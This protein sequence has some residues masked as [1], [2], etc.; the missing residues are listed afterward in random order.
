MFGLIDHVDDKPECFELILLALAVALAQ[1]A[2]LG[3]E[4]H[5]REG[6][7]ALVA[8]ELAENAPLFRLVVVR[9]V[10]PAT[11]GDPAAGCWASSSALGSPTSAG[12]GSG[13]WTAR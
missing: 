6:V 8:V 13:A 10:E 5:A 7:A 4:H 3:V 2:P 9:L 12:R 1:L 11:H